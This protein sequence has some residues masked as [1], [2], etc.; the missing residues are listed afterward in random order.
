MPIQRQLY[1]YCSALR[2]QLV[3]IF[4]IISLWKHIHG[5]VVPFISPSDRRHRHYGTSNYK[6]QHKQDCQNNN[7]ATSSILHRRF[8]FTIPAVANDDCSNDEDDDDDDDEYIDTDSLGDWRNFRRSLSTIIETDDGNNLIDNKDYRDESC[9]KTNEEALTKQD[10]KLAEEYVTS[11]WAHVTSTPEIGGLVV[12]MPLEVELHRNYNH[13]IMGSRLRAILDEDAEG[14]GI[15]TDDL[16]MNHWYYRSKEFIEEEMRNIANLADDN[17]QI[18]ATTL[19]EDY[20]ELLHSYLENQETWQEVCLVVEQNY[21]ASGN[22]QFSKTLALNRPM[23]W[24]LTENLGKLAFLG[25]YNLKISKTAN[26]K[27]EKF[28]KAFQEE[29]ACYV[30]GPNDQGEGSIMIHGIS[31]LPGAIEISPGSKIYLGG[32]DAAVEGVLS[33]K[34]KP[35]Q[36]RFFIG[37][38]NY[39]ESKLDVEV[40]LGKLQPIACTRSLVLKQCKALPTPLWHEVLELCGDELANLSRLEMLKYE[41]LKFQVIDEPEIPDIEDE[42]YDIEIV[43]DEDDD[44]FI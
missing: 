39:N 41:D 35:L 13:S 3:I 17:D 8:S 10:K 19:E 14:V 22:S 32:V 27:L 9:K 11:V 5:F 24:K 37:C 40:R 44:D 42:I 15:P 7:R 33:G 21:T 2:I 36:F 30:G 20:D 12:R 38:H 1:R 28:M 29:F 6:I 26:K 43:E 16:E 31:N 18:D 23:G 34:Y 4:A 25:A